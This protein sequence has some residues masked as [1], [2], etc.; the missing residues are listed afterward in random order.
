MR[1]VLT[2]AAGLVGTALRGAL[3]EGG[4][5][6]TRLVR[7]RAAGP[8]EVFWD[9]TSGRIDRAGLEGHDA[10]VHLAG[11]S[12]VGRWSREKKRRIRD[13]RV[14]GTRLLVGA[15]CNLARP[16]QVFV[17]ASA[18]GYYGDRGSA[19]LQ[20]TDPPGAGFLAGVCREWEA[21][22]E[23]VRGAGSRLV[24]L[25]SGLILAADG[26]ALASM[27][28]MFR[29]GLGA[30]LGDGS[31]WMSWI[32]LRDAVGVIRHALATPSLEG[33]V[34][35]VAPRPVTNAEFTQALAQALSRP[36][37]L[38][39][40]RLALRIALG[41]MARELLLAS[42]RVEPA[43][44]AAIGYTFRDPTLAETLGRLLASPSALT[45]SDPRTGRT[46]P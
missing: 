44:L 12:L 16:P 27:L 21:E 41:E 39:V 45:A 46:A 19:M 25:R 40:P 35:N 22:A 11:E 9:P 15:I 13:S 38:R 18:I 3:E 6:V 32:S 30:T 36:A 33:P 31:Q 10:V 17:S 7:G 1:T 26:G 24:L 20:E 23:P 34:N 42:T 4:H 2:G 8:G 28:P 29:R 37:F 14:R 43:R 5:E